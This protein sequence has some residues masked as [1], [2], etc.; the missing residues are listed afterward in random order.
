MGCNV[1][2]LVWYLET[3]YSVRSIPFSS[4]VT[5]IQTRTIPKTYIKLTMFCPSL[6]QKALIIQAQSIPIKCLSIHRDNPF[7]S[8]TVFS[9]HS[10]TWS[11]GSCRT[12]AASWRTIFEVTATWAPRSPARCL[13]L[14]AW[15]SQAS[16]SSSSVTWAAT[17]SW[18][19]WCSLCRWG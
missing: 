11:C 7:L 2:F 1:R 6:I 8:R 18:P 9:P 17:T 16:S 4:I 13:I 15:L 10:P 5:I 12:L 3:Q 14:P 19:L